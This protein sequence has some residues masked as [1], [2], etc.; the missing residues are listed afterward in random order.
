MTVTVHDSLTASKPLDAPGQPDPAQD[1][2]PPQAPPG[3]HRR[4]GRGRRRSAAFL[5]M[6]L[7]VSGAT[8]GGVVSALDRPT[9]STTTAGSTAPVV[10]AARF[11]T[12]TSTAS[13]T[14][15]SAAA[16]IARSVV[17]ITV[18]GT[19]SGAGGTGQVE[20]TGS[21]IVL[22]TKG[23]IVTNN[24][25][26]AAAVSAGG[27]G[28]ISVTLSDGTSHPATVVGTDATIDLAVVKVTGVTGFTPATFADSSDLAVGQTVLAVGA[29]LGLSN[30][31]TEGIVSSLDR[32]VATGEADVTGADQ[33]SVYEAVQTDAAINPGN[34]GGALV[35][36]AGRV[37]GLNSAIAST[38]DSSTSQSGNIGVGF[39][40]PSDTVVDVADQLVADGSATHSQL[41]VTVS[42][43]SDDSSST[44]DS[45]VTAD[46]A[47]LSAVT[48][49]GPAAAAGLQAG[50]AVTKVGDLTVTDATS[51]MAAVRAN[52][53]GTSVTVTYVR[54]G[55]THTATVTLIAAV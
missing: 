14:P 25:V 24:H 37:V 38:S 55:S 15:Q 50:D 10:A 43:S 39:A 27:S 49:G 11:A 32:P 53:P 23:D 41:G 21:G 1:Q 35:D 5:A 33:Q 40:I 4:A 46:G 7:L 28:T 13:G 36:L 12:G 42:S 34:S 22:D 31:V 52:D 2:L 3:E 9:T 44:D 29:P 26:V 47:T 8:G 51:L 16:T 30:T 54:G 18:I 6:A 48:A 45:S 19:T 20:D 17:T